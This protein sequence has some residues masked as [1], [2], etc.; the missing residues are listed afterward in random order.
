MGGYP[1]QEALQYSHSGRR[2]LLG[3]GTD[4]FGIWDRE[5][6][7]VPASRFPRTNEGWIE[8]WTRY[9]ALEP[10]AIEVGLRGGPAAS[11]TP[12]QVRG[13]NE[14]FAVASLVLGIVGLLFAILAVL[15]LVFGYLA[16]GRIRRSGGKLH[17]SG[18]ATAGIVLGWIETAIL[19]L[20]VVLVATGRLQLPRG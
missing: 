7:R 6:L 11:A 10:D 1:D 12:S 17:G 2:Y 16:R 5:A 14:P 9:S 4:F 20:Y 15:A 8:A 3:Y 18:M 19:V 13:E